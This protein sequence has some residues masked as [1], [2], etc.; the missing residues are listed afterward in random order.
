MA[1]ASN[2][3][4]KSRPVIARVDIGGRIFVGDGKLVEGLAAP[5]AILTLTPQ[6]ES[7]GFRRGD[8]ESGEER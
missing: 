4:E 6:P 2:Q 1:I 8:V 5:V 3:A 7:A